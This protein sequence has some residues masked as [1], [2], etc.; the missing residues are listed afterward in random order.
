VVAGRLEKLSEFF[1]SP[2]FLEEKMWL[3]L[4]T[5][6]RE[7]TQRLDSDEFI[8]IV[9]MSLGQALEMISDGEI[10]DAKTIIGL[11]LAAP[12]VGAITLGPDYPAV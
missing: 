2:G 9:R 7:T 3:Y 8:E 12:R 11:L 10:Q 6:L 1:V 4:A 5:D